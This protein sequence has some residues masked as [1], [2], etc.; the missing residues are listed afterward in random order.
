MTTFT[1]PAP[2]DLMMIHT[3]TK[4]SIFSINTACLEHDHTAKRILNE[5]TRSTATSQDW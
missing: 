1:P 4:H 3:H 5:L 2:S